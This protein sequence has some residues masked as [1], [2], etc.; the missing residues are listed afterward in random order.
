MLSASQMLR[1]AFGSSNDGLSLAE[2][3]AVTRLAASFEQLVMEDGRLDMKSE[4][5]YNTCSVFLEVMDA[6]ARTLS[7]EPAT[8]AYRVDF[9]INYRAL[10]P[11]ESRNYRVDVLEASAEQYAMIWVNGDKFEFTA[12][13]MRRAGALQSA[14]RDVKVVLQRWNAAR[15]HPRNATRP[16]RADLTQVLIMLDFAWASFEQKYITELIAIEDKAR[17]CIVDAIKHEQCLRQFEKV[18]GEGRAVQQLPSYREELS[19]LTKCICKLNS[20]ANVNRKG[21]DDLDVTILLDAYGTIHRCDLADRDQKGSD[22]MSTA[23]TLANDVTESF[24]AMRNYLRQVSKCLER[25]DPNLCNNAGLVARLVDWEESWE[26]GARY[27]QHEKLLSAV[28]DVVSEIRAAQIL[29]PTLRTMIEDCDVE[30]FL[31]LPRII[32]LRFMAAPECSAELL[33]S[34]LPHKF[35]ESEQPVAASGSR[36]V[37]DAELATSISKYQQ[38]VQLFS[39]HGSVA[40]SSEPESPWATLVRRMVLGSGEDAKVYGVLPRGLRDFAM[41]PIEDL[42][43]DLEKHSIELQRHCPEDWNQCSAILLQCLAGGS[44]VQN[45]QDSFRV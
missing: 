30:M 44:N 25:V 33:R 43:K 34:L 41:R 45:K 26:V 39:D 37:W 11:D 15:D 7:L 2:E 10:F 29:A 16:S 24:G 21:R 31:V 28:C 23:R 12:E 19:R 8:R 42:V 14:W 36:H 6:C 18:H 13:A 3:C 1:K 35:V 4:Q 40:A 32:W 20:I 27:V 5:G 9:T 38:V 22:A 17:R